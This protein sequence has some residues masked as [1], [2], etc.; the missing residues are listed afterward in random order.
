MEALCCYILLC[1]GCI[2]GSNTMTGKTLDTL[3]N[4][5][6]HVTFNM[7]EAITLLSYSISL[8]IRLQVQNLRNVSIIGK[9]YVMILLFYKPRCYFT[10]KD[11][12]SQLKDTRGQD[13][14][15]P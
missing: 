14:G 2:Q 7:P 15:S 5:K 9:Y 6:V 10:Y 11:N 3:L 8:R 1:T 12:R 4:A 13:T